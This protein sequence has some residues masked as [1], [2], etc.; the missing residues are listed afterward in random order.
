MKTFLDTG[1]LIAAW[2]ATKQES[3]AALAVITDESRQLLTSEVVKLEILPKPIFFKQ[4]DEV[5][6]YRE[7]FSRMES[8]PMTE[9]LYADAYELAKTHG[10]AAGDAFNLA[11]AIRL[12]AKEFVTTEK[13]ARAIFRVNQLRVVSLHAATSK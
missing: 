13:P 2:H 7:I 8:E 11:A 12:Q 10:L 6:F 9:A 4:K 3:T 1:V 5:A